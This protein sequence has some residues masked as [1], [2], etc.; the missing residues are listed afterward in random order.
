VRRE[1]RREAEAGKPCVG[2]L[3]AAVAIVCEVTVLDVWPH[4]PLQELQI[5]CVSVPIMGQRQTQ[6]GG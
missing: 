1:E 5:R 3:G 2:V 4:D 6:R